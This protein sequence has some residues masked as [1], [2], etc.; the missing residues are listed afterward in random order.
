MP[1][2]TIY[3]PHELYERLMKKCGKRKKTFS[4]VIQELIER[5]LD[6]LED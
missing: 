6:K 5:Y 4:G 1:T 3:L 2:I